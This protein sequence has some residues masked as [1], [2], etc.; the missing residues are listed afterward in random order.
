LN[1]FETFHSA[2]DLS[3]TPDVRFVTALEWPGAKERRAGS[4]SPTTPD[5]CVRERFA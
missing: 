4:S 5:E 2:R 3:T 1:A